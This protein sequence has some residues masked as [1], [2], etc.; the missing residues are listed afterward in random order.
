MKQKLNIFYPP[1]NLMSFEDSKYFQVACE[2]SRRAH[3][4]EFHFCKLCGKEDRNACPFI[5]VSNQVEKV[6]GIATYFWENPT[7]DVHFDESHFY[8]AVDRVYATLRTIVGE[9]DV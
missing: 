2:V 4:S 1:V 6:F 3:S 7:P 5:K 9:A 8:E